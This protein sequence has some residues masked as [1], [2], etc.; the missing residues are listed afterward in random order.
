MLI[1][2]DEPVIVE[3]VRF[4]LEDPSVR[5]SRGATRPEALE[6][7]RA[8]P[9][10]SHPARRAHAR[11]RPGWRCASASAGIL[12]SPARASSCSPPPARRGDRLLAR[13]AGAD[14]YLT[15]P[16]SPLKLLEIVRSLLPEGPAWLPR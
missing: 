5:L 15:K 12:G 9:T 14:E 16:F 1:A 10:G 6:L 13:T 2:D 7:A 4:T 11:P 8:H 3:L